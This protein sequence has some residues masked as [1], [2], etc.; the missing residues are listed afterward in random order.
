MRSANRLF[1]AVARSSQF[2]EPG[3]PTGLT[4]L[5]THG[6]PRTALLYLYNATLQKLKDLPEHSVYRQSTEALTK[7]RLS[8]IESTKP[9]GLAEWQQR[10]EPLI[11]QHKSAFRKEPLSS[12]G[13]EYNIVWKEGVEQK[14]IEGEGKRIDDEPVH[15]EGPTTPEDL[16]REDKIRARYAKELKNYVPQIEAEP[17][18]TIEQIGDIETK[19]SAGL[20]EEIIEVAHSENELVSVMLE[21][22]VWEDLEEKPVEGQ[23]AYN[24]RDRHTSGTGLDPV[25]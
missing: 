7:H 12:G 14:Q 20:I 4:G 2:L 3:A 18:L 16:E 21:N 24:E 15:R 8:I 17:P 10:V 25:S 6:S 19:I 5:K 22:K 13:S 9:A 11:Q 23:W 1:A